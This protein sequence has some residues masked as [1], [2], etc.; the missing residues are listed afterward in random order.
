MT[1]VTAAQQAR[2]TKLP[3]DLAEQL[4]QLAEDRR[5]SVSA[6]LRALIEGAV[7]DAHGEPQRG[8]VERQV[9][10]EIEEVGYRGAPGRIAVA[11]EL[12]RHL[13]STSANS[14]AV[15]AQIRMIMAELRAEMFTHRGATTFDSVVWFRL[16]AALRRLGFNIVDG[17]GRPFDVSADWPTDGA[18]DKILG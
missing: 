15:A 18:F 17:D 5:V 16:K 6:F 14:P 10:A 8:E 11:L 4:D 9:P 2:S 3:P 12:A 7:A 13:D 1:D